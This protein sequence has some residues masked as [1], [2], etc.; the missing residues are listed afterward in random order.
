[1]V[2]IR[3][4]EYGTRGPTVVVLHGG[5]GAPG[6]MVPVA[7][8][9]ATSFRVLEPAQR[10]SGKVR[11]TVSRH[12]ED[13]DEL[14]R[15]TL[16]SDERAALVGSSWGAMLALAY[17]AAHPTRVGPIVLIGCGTFDV[18]ARARFT[19]TLARRTTLAVR[20]RLAALTAEFPNPDDA[21]A[22][23]ARVLL[24]LY[25]FD[26]LDD[27]SAPSRLDA[28]GARETWS[29]M[30]RL[31]ENGTYPSRFRAIRAPVLMLHGSYDPH[32]GRMILAGLRPYLPHIEYH[33][34][35]HCGHYPWLEREVREDFFAV[36]TT[37]LSKHLEPTQ[38][39]R[40]SP[41]AWE[42]RRTA[43]SQHP[44]KRA[45]DAN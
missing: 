8:E 6:Q 18:A 39:R 14:L 21:L 33:E 40:A 11:L 27:P 34:W 10:R 43:S 28:R 3:F 32:P 31:Q 35:A 12:V 16:R 5:P 41:G 22:V 15:R 2:L 24:P 37:W 26:P 20:A 45:R 25:S 13:L 4:R 29:D 30:L 7:R 44:R 17:G 9:L 38:V 23:E 36:L 1:M 19:A 42:A